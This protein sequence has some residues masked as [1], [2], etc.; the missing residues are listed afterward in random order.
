M[1]ALGS[2]PSNT[3]HT[4]TN[5]PLALQAP[6]G[7][8]SP[9]LYPKGKFVIP[10]SPSAA[11]LSGSP[12]RSFVPQ[13]SA[14]WPSFQRNRT[15]SPFGTRRADSGP[16]SGNS[17]FTFRP[18]AVRPASTDHDAEV[19]I[20]SLNPWRH[21]QACCAFG[22]PST[23]TG[24]EGEPCSAIFAYYFLVRHLI[25]SSGW[26][27]LLGD[28]CLRR[29]EQLPKRFATDLQWSCMTPETPRS[30]LQWVWGT[31][32]VECV[33]GTGPIAEKECSSGVPGLRSALTCMPAGV[34]V[35]LRRE[36]HQACLQ[37][38][39]LRRD[40]KVPRCS[41]GE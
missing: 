30:L 39:W 18:P 15:F 29:D 37:A 26:A 32:Q 36:V 5:H 35:S 14:P 6:A 1:C 38:G 24:T 9:S 19:Q 10:T 40:G 7:R 13:P 25:P 12:S 33:R 22:V 31:P 11:A 28:R 27:V 17:S 23:T 4:H 2:V 20:T 41:N 34:A 16:P 3:T 21:V 8:Q